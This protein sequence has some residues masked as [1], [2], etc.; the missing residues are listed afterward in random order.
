[1][2]GGTLVGT[3]V[4]EVLQETGFDA[5]DLAGEVDR[6]LSVRS[7]R[8]TPTSATRADVVAGLVTAIEAPLGPL[9]GDLRLRRSGGRTASTR[10]GSR[11]RSSAGDGPAPARLDVT[12][13]GGP[14]RHP[15]R[16]GRPGARL[17]RAA[18]CAG[19]RRRCCAAT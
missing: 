7:V 1:M 14:P 10:W 18:A 13:I 12:D 15:P 5:T 6:A 19:A 11:S 9:V 17:R 8:G 16:G 3:V 4:H 2:P